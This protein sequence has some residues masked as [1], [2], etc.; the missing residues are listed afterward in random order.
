MRAVP[1]TPSEAVGGH[2]D[3]GA[4][5]AVMSAFPTG[6]AVVTTIDGDGCPRGL[7]CS[8]LAS[9]TLSPPTLLVCVRHGSTT[10]DAMLACGRFAVN[11]LHTRGQ[12]AAELFSSPRPDRFTQLAWRPT[13]R[14][15]MPWL[16]GAAFAVAECLV[17]GTYAV[18]DHTVAFGEVVGT[19]HQD[20]A[21][22]LYGLR[23]YSAWPEPVSR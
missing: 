6:V 4:Y 2:V 9:V 12:H 20:G 3:V 18:G 14:L 16:T 17:S 11:L 1:G 7:T 10:L 13:N 21:P 15:A 22:L 19:A 23:R 8:S 5:R